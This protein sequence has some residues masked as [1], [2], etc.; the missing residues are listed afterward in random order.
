MKI[1]QIDNDNILINNKHRVTI[2]EKN[3]KKML[4]FEGKM[5]K[6]IKSLPIEEETLNEI[7]DSGSV[8]GYDTKLSTYRN[9]KDI[10]KQLYEPYETIVEEESH[11]N[12]TKIDNYRDANKSASDDYIASLEETLNIV[13]ANIL[14]AISPN[15]YVDD[16]TPAARNQNETLLDLKYDHATP[17]YKEKLTTHLSGDTS[18]AK[19]MDTAIKRAEVADKSTV[20]NSVVFGRDIEVDWR[21]IE[22]SGGK[23]IALLGFAPLK[24]GQRYRFTLTDID[25]NVTPLSEEM[26]PEKAKV[27]GLVFEMVDGKDNKQILEWK[28][29]KA[30]V[31]N[32]MRTFEIKKELKKIDKIFNYKNEDKPTKRPNTIGVDFAQQLKKVKQLNNL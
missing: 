5:Y 30:T 1:R 10:K 11:P 15:W 22:N 12:K 32:E 4:F 20:M 9:P 19:M 8:G 29:S 27:E 23:G 25:F 26:I 24:E 17:E 3:G 28:D 13:Y 7:T 21:N 2:K 18:G 31:L 6:D 14:G 16:Q